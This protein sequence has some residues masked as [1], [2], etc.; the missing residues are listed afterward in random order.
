M[1][2]VQI[3][4]LGVVVTILAVTLKGHS[5]QFALI[6]SIGGSMLIFLAILLTGFGVYDIIA[7][8]GGAGTFLPITGFA[9]AMAAAS[10]EHK[11]EGLIVGTSTKLFTV[12]GPVIVNGIVWSTVVGLLRMIIG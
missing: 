9:N 8:E 4:A 12:I 2:I 6:I 7:K 1:D 10:M 11:S 3:V 5:P